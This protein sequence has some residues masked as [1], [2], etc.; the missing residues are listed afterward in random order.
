MRELVEWSDLPL[1]QAISVLM[2]LDFSTG[3]LGIHV[4]DT[5][6]RARRTVAWNI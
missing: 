5:S 3:R 6:R 4:D 2:Y 1:L